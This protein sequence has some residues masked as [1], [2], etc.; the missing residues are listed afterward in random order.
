M[1]KKLDTPLFSAWN[2]YAISIM[3]ALED[4]GMWNKEDTF[5]KF[6]GVTGIA[7]Q[8]C[9]DTHCSALPITDYDWM[10]EH[11]CFLERIGAKTHIYYASPDD[12]AYDY[13]Q[14]QAIDAIKISLNQNRAVVAWGIDTGEFGIIV[15]FD[16]ED[17][18]FFTK[19]IG[20]A[21]T[22]S[23]LPI[24]YK[25][26]GKTFANAP[27]L[28]VEIP[29]SFETIDQKQAY[30][31]SL[32]LYAKEMTRVSDRADRGFGM[33]AYDFLISSLKN[34][35]CDSFGLRYCMGVYYERKEA[36]L[37]YLREIRDFFPDQGIE[38]II[39]GFEQVAG[40]YRQ[41][42]F[43]VLEQGTDGWNHLWRDV[44]KEKYPEII[45]VVKK[46]KEKEVQIVDMINHFVSSLH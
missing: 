30:Y 28:Y 8:F 20:N 40:L 18:V 6:M 32:K 25:N 45:R 3:S 19:G 38:H 15:G 5:Q 14:G 43:D 22:G 17:G 23:S 41:L 1:Y 42:L 31:H 12:P 33:E 13:K 2:T 7:A 11:S 34:D 16:D 35:R 24:L 26:L 29:D 46:M 39:D 4:C 9:I 21:N 44:N 10:T 37:F 27:V 36:M